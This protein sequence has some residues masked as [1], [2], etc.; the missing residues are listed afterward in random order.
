[1]TTRR[2]TLAILALIFLVIPS[3]PCAEGFRDADQKQFE[4]AKGLLDAGIFYEA[5]LEFRRFTEKY[6]RDEKAG[7][8]AYYRAK[9]LYEYGATPKIR[10]AARKAVATF[11]QR[12]PKHPARNLGYFLLGE[13]AMEEALEL[14]REI[15]AR[16]RNKQPTSKLQARFKAACRDAYSNYSKFI[17]LTDLKTYHPDSPLREEMTSRVVTAHYNAAQCLIALKKFRDAI[18][19]YRILVLEPEFA[20]WGREE[21]QFLIGQSY[22]EWGKRLK[23]SSR[24]EKLNLAMAE[25]GRVMFFGLSVGGRSEFS[26]DARLG[27]AWCLF[28]LHKYSECRKLLSDNT[29][30]RQADGRVR[31]SFFEETYNVYRDNPNKIDPRWVRPLWPD[32]Y[33]LYAKCFFAEAKYEEAE[34]YFE[35]VMNMEGENPWKA[36]ATRMFD[37]CRKLI[38]K[39]TKLATEADALKAFKVAR[40]KYLTGRR[41][42]AIKDFEQ[43]WLRFK[44]VRAWRYRDHLLYY[45]G[46]S[47]YWSGDDGRLLEAAAVFN[48]LAKTGNPQTAVTDDRKRSVSV[49]GEASYSEGLS[50]WRLGDEMHAGHEK[51]AIVEAAILAFERL[52]ARNPEHPET[53]ETLLNVGNFHLGEKRYVKAGLAYRRMV[54][55]Y[56]KHEDAP[57]AL[58]NL[59]YVYREL[60]QLNDVV[61]AANTF[62]ANFPKRSDVVRAIDLKGN[63]WFKLAKE[64]EDPEKEKELFGKAAAEYGKLKLERFPWLSSV[65]KEEEYGRIF[66]NALFYTAYSYKKIGDKAKA[67][68]HYRAF[69]KAAPQDNAHLTEGRNHCAELYLEE[70]QYAEAVEVLR[71]LADDLEAPDDKSY[72]GMAMLVSALLER[73]KDEADPAKKKGLTDEAAAR[74]RHFFSIYAGTPIHH[75]PFLTIAGAFEQ[76]ALFEQMLDAYNELKANQRLHL[77]TKG[78]AAAEKRKLYSNYAQLLFKAG[79]ACG[80]AADT[81]EARDADTKKF[82]NATGDFLTEHLDRAKKLLGRG[83]IPANFVKINFEIAKTFKRANEP[84]KGARALEKIIAVVEET[85]PRFLKAYFER[86]NIWLECGHPKRSLASYI[87]VIDWADPDNP[88]RTKYIALSYFQG[89]IAQFRIEDDEQAGAKAKALF[90]TLIRKFGDSKDKEIRATVAKA[91]EQIDKIEKALSEL[92]SGRG[93]E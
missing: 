34:K 63:A 13:I 9:A 51:E 49:V 54:T 18:E 81:L 72:R 62:E 41:E 33:Y 79:E 15:G 48:Y 69:I 91:R 8:A 16:K 58:L 92:E 80:R 4:Y 19:E 67:I 2:L 66:A 93:R 32:I 24:R 77:A 90:E 89:G 50:Y 7:A 35:R 40:N 85:D 23:D 30:R 52:A 12:Y 39:Q 37:E 29:K 68:E 73:A 46:K 26:D 61:W 60:D 47:L 31:P 10:A 5:A 42:D 76:A 44:G 3:S 22:Y 56:P 17:E 59:C 43:I 38:G 57:K 70:G 14:E 84:A 27:E 20:Q 86:G 71:P 53:P 82:D 11:H 88:A 87:Y 64:A 78:L 21:A 65:E 36:E 75:E 74:A 28:E 1:M 83:K 55:L 45:W 6:P 25:Y